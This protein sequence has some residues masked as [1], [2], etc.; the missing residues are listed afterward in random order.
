MSVIGQVR[1]CDLFGKSVDLFVEG[2]SS[3]RTIGGGLVSLLLK[4][5]IFMFFAMQLVAVVDYSDP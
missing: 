3:Y 1:D 4:L 5:L 2:K